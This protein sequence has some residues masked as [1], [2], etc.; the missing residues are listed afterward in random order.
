MFFLFNDSLRIK[1]PSSEYGLYPHVGTGLFKE[2]LRFF[3]LHH[4]A[5]DSHIVVVSSLSVWPL[6]SSCCFVARVVVACVVDRLVVS[7]LVSRRCCL[8]VVLL[9]CRESGCGGCPLS[10]GASTKIQHASPPCNTLRK[11]VARMEFY[12]RVMHTTTMRYALI[13]FSA[14][15]PAHLGCR[16]LCN[17]ENRSRAAL[18]FFANAALSDRKSTG[19]HT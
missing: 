7:S 15:A 4:L 1:V 9:F 13:Y 19:M 3:F 18:S 12:P 11:K 17:L 8:V 6:S 10:R 5:S 16:I 2:L 14:P